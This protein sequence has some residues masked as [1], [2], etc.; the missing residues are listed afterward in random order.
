M[1]RKLL[2]GSSAAVLGV[3]LMVAGAA[4]AAYPTL[5][6][7]PPGSMEAKV[8]AVEDI[9]SAVYKVYGNERLGYWVAKTVV[10]NTGKGPLYDVEISY[11]IEGLTDWSEPHIYKAV[12][13]GGAV[14][15]LYYPK[16]TSPPN[17][18][19]ATPSELYV[20]IRYKTT[21]DSE[22]IVETKKKPITILGSH[23]F[24][25]SGIPPE[26]STGSFQDVFSNYELLAA[27]VTPKDPVVE[28][29]ADMANQLT[30][31]AG[32]SLSDEDAVRYLNAVWEFS[33]YNGI[34]YQTEPPAYW[35]G[36]A[37][38][39]V[40]YP[41]DVIRDKS[42][43]CL[44]TS[45]FMASLAMAHGL[46]PY[47]VLIP[48]H[49]FV[50]VELPSGNLLPIE[51]TL[52]ANKSS[53]ADA[54]KVGVEDV[55]NAF[56][57]PSLMV[58]VASLQASGVVP[59][60]LPELPPNVLEQWGYTLPE[61]A[62]GAPGGG[63]AGGEGAGA[64]GGQ[65]EGANEGGNAG[66]GA[67]PGG[68][69]QGQA[70]TKLVS[71]PLAGPA[72]SLRVPASWTSEVYSNEDPYEVDV[73]SPDYMIFMAIVWSAQYTVN[74]LRQMVEESLYQYTG[75][76]QVSGQGQGQLG[77]VDAVTI[78][79]TLGDGSLAVVRYASVGG[80]SLAVM[81]VLDQS[82]VSQDNINFME[83]IVSTFT[84]NG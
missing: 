12:P 39:Y 43:T 55:Q 40:K 83:N 71:N 35:T 78:A 67:P 57:G 72:W 62:G 50:L 51:T 10:R 56:L 19:S 29:Y 37:A 54:V 81:Y 65:G 60:E 15:D 16:I 28:R 8:Y 9:M 46:K 45:I 1:A 31:G 66:G 14:V 76:L 41:R 24:V 47:I 58:D 70:E 53:F 82:L 61:P 80:Y 59:P 11:K 3:V 44:D 17:L 73:Y 7:S 21:L 36:K 34:T 42:G 49:A 6:S 23:D 63:G 74:D 25:F 75:D 5:A 52:L 79:Y 38:Q 68:G 30:G 77:G 4:L 48:G 32:A 13:P 27:W 33:V 20:K 84:L 64:G 69:G 18:Q 22:P 2:P 26:E